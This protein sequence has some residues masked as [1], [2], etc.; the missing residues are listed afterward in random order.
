M[1]VHD[2]LENSAKAYP[3]KNAVWYKDTWMTYGEIDTLSNKVA[4]HLVDTGIKRGDRVAI[5]FENSFDY[6]IAYYGILKAGAVTVALNTET[7]TDALV[8]L[9]N[10]SGAKAIITQ[11]KFSRY[12]VPAIPEIPYL[13]T[14]VI[15]ATVSRYM[16][17]C[18]LISTTD[19][20]TAPPTE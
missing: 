10:D 7:N 16:P 11:Q 2:I 6:I 9:L 14:V 8:Y 13:K 1:Q 3:E 15:R 12:L 17:R 4:D 19:R 20:T 5:L 18:Q